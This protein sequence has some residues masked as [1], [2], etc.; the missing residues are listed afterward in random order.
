MSIDYTTSIGDYHAAP[1]ISASKLRTFSTRGP[2]FYHAKYVSR[3]TPDEPDSEALVFG[4][5]LEDLVQGRG[6][7]REQYAVKP[8][9]LSFATK[10]GKAWRAAQQAAGKSIVGSDDMQR[11][12]SMRESLG[13]NETALEMIRVCKAQA[14]LRCDYAGTPGL[15][16][17]PDWLSDVGCLTSG[18]APF[19]L[20]LKSTRSLAKLANGRGVLEFG[21]HCQAAIVRRLLEAN[22]MRGVRFY[23][24]ACEKALPFRCQVIEMPQEWLDAGWRWCERQLSKLARHYETNNWPRVEQELIQLPPPPAWIDESQDEEENAA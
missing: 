15:Q 1:Y 4:Q 23:L 7:D 13:D 19:S 11:M 22:G 18:Y 12:D 17:R 21:Y 6:L 8:D 24:L 20:D 2:R 3:S 14:T 16:A 5:V 9:G 10:E